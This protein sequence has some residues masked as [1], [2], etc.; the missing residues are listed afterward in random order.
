MEYHKTTALYKIYIS[1]CYAV[2]RS[3][4][5]FLLDE[6]YEEDERGWM[7]EGAQYMCHIYLN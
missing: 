1:A 2:I 4:I 7:G 6:M 3:Y 5:H